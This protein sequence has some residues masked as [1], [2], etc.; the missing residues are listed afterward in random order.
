M[1][2]TGLLIG[3]LMLLGALTLGGTIALI[4]AGGS[5]GAAA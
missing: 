1:A 4:I 5:F 3:L 2:R